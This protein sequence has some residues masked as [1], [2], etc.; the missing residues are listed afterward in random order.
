MTDLGMAVVVGR[1]ALCCLRADRLARLM[2]ALGFLGGVLRMIVRNGVFLWA[3][4]VAV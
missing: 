2:R 4:E 3:R 1:A